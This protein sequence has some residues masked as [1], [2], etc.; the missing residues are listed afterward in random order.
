ME[1]FIVFIVFFVIILFIVLPIGIN[2]PL[3]EER[4]EA[5]K[6]FD[7][8]APKEA[9]IGIKLLSTTICA[10]IATVLFYFFVGN[11]HDRIL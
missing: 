6:A 5:E 3:K 1:N 10:I 8:G 2:A 4:S 7:S 9:Y 11:I